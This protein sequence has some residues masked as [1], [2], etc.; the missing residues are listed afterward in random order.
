MYNIN[1]NLTVVTSSGHQNKMSMY[2]ENA[3]DMMH[4]LTEHLPVG[5]IEEHNLMIE[6][7]K[8]IDRY[9]RDTL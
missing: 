9:E 4:S 5:T 2:A 8:L 7:R 3:T 6:I 1:V